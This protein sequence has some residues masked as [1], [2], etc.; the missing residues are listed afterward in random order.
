MPQFHEV[1]VGD[2]FEAECIIDEVSKVVRCERGRQERHQP[3]FFVPCKQKHDVV[4]AIV[5]RGTCSVHHSPHC[6]Q[7]RTSA[8][9]HDKGVSMK[10][11]QAKA[12]VVVISSFSREN[13]SLELKKMGF[14]HSDVLRANSDMN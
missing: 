11:I 5:Q 6:H 9:Y 12:W 1:Q 8:S 3:Q 7:L 13:G 14:Q 2:M 4:Y 10:R